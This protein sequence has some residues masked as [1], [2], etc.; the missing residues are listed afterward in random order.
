MYYKRRYIQYNDLVFGGVDVID[1]DDYNVSFKSFSSEYGFGHGS[2]A[3]WKGAFV[4]SGSVSLTI[5]LRMK[6]LPCE[7]RPFYVRFA[8]SQL[9]KP[10]RL[11]AIQDNRLIWAWAYPSGYSEST[12]SKKDELEID[13]NFDIPEGV[14]HKADKLKTF[15]VP[16]AVCDFMDCY[17]Y[18]EIDPCN[19]FCCDCGREPK[20]IG[21][22]Y[23]TDFSCCGC[24]GEYSCCG[25]CDQVSEENALC[26]FK[27][28]QDFYD[29]DGGGFKIIYSCAA[30]DKFFGDFLKDE[31]PGQKFCATCGDAASGILY[32]D[33]DIPTEGVKITIHGKVKDPYIEINGNGNSILGEYDGVL[34]VRPDGSVYNYVEG[35]EKCDPL[36]VD[37]WSI[38]PGMSYGWTVDQGKN[39]V[40]I[41]GGSCCSYCAWIEVDALTI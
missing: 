36:P 9:T 34:E 32:S 19:P 7:D 12:R 15:L 35:C 29:C 31:H 22:C 8:K 28:L 18:H 14:W 16:F 2:Y 37:V 21:K 40:L 24:P 27:D 5:I 41:D 33:T 3:P 39:R 23:P 11:W 17:D 6:Q 25:D 30:A 1:E 20:G 4:R 13:V 26:Y 10:G 38:M